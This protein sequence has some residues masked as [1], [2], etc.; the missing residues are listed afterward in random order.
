MQANQDKVSSKDK[1]QTEYKRIRTKISWR[2]Q[3]FLHKSRPALGPIELPTQ[4]VMRLFPGGKA[5]G[6]WR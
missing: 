1:V 4:W 2:R 6:S 5:A 3:D